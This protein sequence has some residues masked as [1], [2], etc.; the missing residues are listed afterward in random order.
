M[1]YFLDKRIT[2]EMVEE[3]NDVSYLI[4]CSNSLTNKKFKMTITKQQ[5]DKMGDNFTNKIKSKIEIL[6]YK[7]F[8]L[9]AL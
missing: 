9:R 5:I 6:F 7:S 8:P 4:T 2:V 1:E 3:K